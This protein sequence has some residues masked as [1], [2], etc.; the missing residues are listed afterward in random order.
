MM[1][2]PRGGGPNETHAFTGKLLDTITIQIGV[3]RYLTLHIQIALDS[4][5]L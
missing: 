4:W 3:D 1:P 2:T 5:L